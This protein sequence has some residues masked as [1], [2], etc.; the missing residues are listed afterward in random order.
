MMFHN[1]K[2]NILLVDDI[3]ANLFSISNMLQSKDYNIYTAGSGNEALSLMIDLDFSLVLLDVMM[4]DMDG[5]E[6]AEIMKSRE[7]TRWIP[8]IFI[9]A[10]DDEDI[11]FKGY[12]S[13]AIDF[14]FKPINPVILKS[15]VKVFCDLHLKNEVLNK[16]LE[17]K[18]F[19]IKEIHHRVKN[20]LIMINSFI[21][22]QRSSERTDGELE[23]LDEVESRIASIML[24]HKKLYSGDNFKE[25]NIGEYLSEISTNLI[26]NLNDN[27]ELKLEVDFDSLRQPVDAAISLGLILTEMMTNSIKYAFPD[28]RHGKITL[29][30]DF[31][32]AA[33]QYKFSYS[34]DGIGISEEELEANSSSLGLTLIKGIAKQLKGDL[35]MHTNSGT[36]YELYFPG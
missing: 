17:E 31:N 3:K 18:E 2:I 29:S 15:K 23:L 6:V 9:T 13:G 21:N 20:N 27:R 8:I 19:L 1:N 26:E 28:G 10:M 22:L 12:E 33:N 24:I 5:F 11:M 36:R 25:V 35:I 14:L 4:P 32:E 30:F 16:A 34:D 7:R